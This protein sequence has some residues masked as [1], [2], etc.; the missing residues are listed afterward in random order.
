MLEKTI[1]RCIVKY[2][3]EK[4]I[5]SYKFASPANRSVPDRIFINEYGVI[6]FIEFKRPGK[7]L[8][9][10]QQFTYNK[11]KKRNCNIHIVDSIEQGQFLIDNGFMTKIHRP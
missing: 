5:I 6:V 11:F 1:E 10:L 3:K 7:S 9:K 2:A 8:S 4:G